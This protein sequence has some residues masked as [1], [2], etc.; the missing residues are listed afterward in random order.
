VSKHDFILAFLKG[1][2]YNDFKTFLHLSLFMIKTILND[3]KQ[4]FFSLKEDFKNLPKELKLV[5]VLYFLLCPLLLIS[6]ESIT[7]SYYFIS[8]FFLYQLLQ[9]NQFKKANIHKSY[10]FLIF[11]I[12]MFISSFWSLNKLYSFKSFIYILLHII[13]FFPYLFYMRTL[14][15]LHKKIFEKYI[16]LG[17]VFSGLFIIIDYCFN[18]HFS[19][20]IKKKN[21]EYF[22]MIQLLFISLSTVPIYFSKYKIYIKAIFFIILFILSYTKLN[23]TMAASTIFFF[24]G[25]IIYKY[26][27]TILKPLF[28]SYCIFFPFLMLLLA[29]LSSFILQSK[30]VIIREHSWLHRLDIFEKC[31][32][33]INTHPL[34]GN[35]FNHLYNVKEKQSAILY[36]HNQDAFLNITYDFTHPHNYI[37]QIWTDLGLVGITLYIFMFYIFINKLFKNINKHKKQIFFIITL[38]PHLL[39][40]LSL[41]NRQW[42]SFVFLVF[43]LLDNE[44]EDEKE[45]IQKI[46][47][48]S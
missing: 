2:L 25:C 4:D 19:T 13:F 7:I 31:L 26:K 44:E 11:L 41:F 22:Y 46:E 33:Y 18:Y 24:I 37:I 35:G 36:D 21:P 38:L 8:A 39:F 14:S 9:K 34:I 43:P 23:D 17:C 12:W 28:F 16:I 20:I 42:W 47:A 30:T 27:P 40:A 32:N 3:F 6:K 29:N 48:S 10:F 45:N 15:S 5:A 1:F